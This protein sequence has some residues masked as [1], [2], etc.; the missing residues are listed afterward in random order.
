MGEDLKSR[1]DLLLVSDCVYYEQSLEPLVK[2]ER[3]TNICRNVSTIFSSGDHN[4]KPHPP[5]IHCPAF[6]WEP[7]GKR[8]FLSSLPFRCHHIVFPGPIYEAF[9]PLLANHFHSEQLCQS[10]SEHG[11]S[12]YLIKLTKNI[13]NKWQIFDIY[14]TLLWHFT[15]NVVVYPTFHIH[16]KLTNSLQNSVTQRCRYLSY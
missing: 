14:E 10:Q 9:F 2:F 1:I 6:L 5:I 3:K 12:V 7:T 8:F 4:G 13:E 16:S 11:N 15:P